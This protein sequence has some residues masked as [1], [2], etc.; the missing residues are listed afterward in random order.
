M[1]KKL[2]SVLVIILLLTSLGM[3]GNIFAATVNDYDIL[4]EVIPPS[5]L[6]G[7][8]V[9]FRIHADLIA[10]GG[11]PP[12]PDSYL[13]YV[14]VRGYTA[15][16]TAGIFV[17]YPDGTSTHIDNNLCPITIYNGVPNEAED[18][19][20][21]TFWGSTDQVGLYWVDFS[22]FL[23]MTDGSVHWFDI[24]TEFTVTTC[25]EGWEGYTPGWWGSNVAKL[26]GYQRGATQI[27]LEDYEAAVDCVYAHWGSD[28]NWLPTDAQGAYAIFTAGPKNDPVVKARIHLLAFLLTLCH[29]GD[30]FGPVSID[31]LTMTPAE[32]AVFL[33]GQYNTGNYASVYYYANILNNY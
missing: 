5:V 25:G 29:F 11:G 13:D 21:I 15:P 16:N 14:E 1:E 32:W 8:T 30:D 27:T 9:T 31:S 3:V 7:G 26:L 10:A 12:P 17:R 22:G 18:Y 20:D 19:V 28:L 2:A 24:E 23:H 33:I 6:Q 4:I